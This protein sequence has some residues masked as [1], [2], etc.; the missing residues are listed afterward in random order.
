VPAGWTRGGGAR[1]VAGLLLAAG[2]AADAAAGETEWRTE[3][4]RLKRQVG[5]LSEALARARLEADGLRAGADR[6]REARAAGGEATLAVTEFAVREVSRDL[7][8]LVVDGGRPQG[9]RPG[10]A[11]RVVRGGRTV[12]RARVVDVRVRIAGA[13][14][15][16]RTRWQ[17]P[18]TGDRAVVDGSR[19]E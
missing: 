8:L 19:K 13:V 4:E 5:Y 12:A 9:L 15:E 16:D 1:G 6:A 2:L 3:A 18:E 11:L 10:M 17:Y 14:I 7:G